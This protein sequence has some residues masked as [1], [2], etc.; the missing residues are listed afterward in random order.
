MGDQNVRT[1][2]AALAELDEYL[3][4]LQKTAAEQSGETKQ[5]AETT[6]DPTTHPVQNKDEQLQPATEGARSAENEADVTSDVGPQNINDAPESKDEEPKPVAM[7]EAE[8]TGEDPSNETAGVK[9]TKDDPGTSAPARVGTEKDGGYLGKVKQACEQYGPEKVASELGNSIM[10]DISVLSGGGEEKEASGEDTEKAAEAGA[11]A[12]DE[13]LQAQVDQA[14]PQVV[15][16]TIKEAEYDAANLAQFYINFQKEQEK[17]GEGEEEPEE[18]VAGEED[19]EEPGEA[20]EEGALPAED[21]AQLAAAAGG[22][23]AAG[24]V[25]AGGVPP[26]VGG[27]PAE[28]LPPEGAPA[29]PSDEEVVEALSE[30]L[31]DAGV[32]PEELAAGVEAQEGMGEMPV[33]QKMAAVNIAKLAA[34]E[35]NRYRNLKAAGRGPKEKKASIQ[36]VWSVRQ[37]IKDVMGK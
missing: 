10:A 21:L 28:G 36:L 14:L 2:G 8:T 35:V 18:A 20:G 25:P 4:A 23:E 34:S 22:P 30:A 9:H 27:A 24:A 7:T 31:A 16:N 37:M 26:E 1:Y 13:A 32:T 15:Q 3:G 12:A 29:E 33:E 11:K 19:T 5:A 6:E 17:K